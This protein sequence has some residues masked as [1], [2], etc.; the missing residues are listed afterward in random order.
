MQN[1]I[2]LK[3]CHSI[4]DIFTYNFYMSIFPCAVMS[5]V[6]YLTRSC[7]QDILLPQI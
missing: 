4:Q 3:N 5:M 7:D 2:V 6:K 1:I